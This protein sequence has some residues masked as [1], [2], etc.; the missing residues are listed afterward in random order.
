M[1]AGDSLAT[2]YRMRTLSLFD[3]T[4]PSGNALHRAMAHCKMH[5]ATKLD[6]DL[7]RRISCQEVVLALMTNLASTLPSSSWHVFA[8]I[9]RNTL[10]F[11]R[12]K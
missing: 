2:H 5:A 10:V 4:A 7:F 8:G 9:Y 11:G 1:V 6:R 12:S 3:P